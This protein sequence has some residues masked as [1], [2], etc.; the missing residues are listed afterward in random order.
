MAL[1]ATV[2]TITIGATSADI[3]HFDAGYCTWDAAEQAHVTWGI[4]PPW[5]GDAGDWIDGA[6]GAGWN[7]SSAPIPNSIV[8]MPRGVQGSG[9]LGHVGWVLAV[10]DDGATVQVRSMNWSGRGVITVHQLQVDGN[11]QFLTPPVSP[12]TPLTTPH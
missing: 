9:A 1:L 5:Y 11:I 4:F 6:R 10:A 3:N 2:L 8:A 12:E 7:V